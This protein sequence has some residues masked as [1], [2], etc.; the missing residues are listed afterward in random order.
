MAR[1][2][3]TRFI[4]PGAS[5]G[6]NMDRERRVL[7]YLSEALDLIQ[8]GHEDY[9]PI[10]GRLDN[11]AIAAGMGGW[12]AVRESIDDAEDCFLMG[13]YKASERALDMA[14]DRLRHQRNER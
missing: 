4:R 7:R 14:M 9:L 1:I 8:T 12:P 10:L 3:A 13:R 5:V 6:A 2:P 11:A